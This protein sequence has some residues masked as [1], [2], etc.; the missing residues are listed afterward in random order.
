MRMISKLLAATILVTS[1]AVA[2]TADNSHYVVVGHFSQDTG[3]IPRLPRMAP[4][5]FDDMMQAGLKFGDQVTF[6]GTQA[7]PDDWFMDITLSAKAGRAKPEHL[8]DFLDQRLADFASVDAPADGS[9][10]WWTLDQMANHTDCTAR[11]THIYV[12]SNGFSASEETAEGKMRGAGIF[13]GSLESCHVTMVGLAAY[14]PPGTSLN[15]RRSLEHMFELAI[16]QGGAAS[17]G[18]LN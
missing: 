13:P 14:A 3:A 5:I 7:A 4:K 9:E 11:E 10:L 2:E 12:I 16:T 17:Y 18:V 6:M 15:Q 1:T 8:A